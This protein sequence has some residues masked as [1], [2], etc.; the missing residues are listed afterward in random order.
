MSIQVSM[1]VANNSKLVQR[2]YVQ[3]S[4]HPDFPHK[5]R[6]LG[7]VWLLNSKEWVFSPKDEAKV[8]ALCVDLF[9]TDGAD[10]ESCTVQ[11][12][13]GGDF[14]DGDINEIWMFGRPVVRRWQRDLRVVLGEDVVIID[15]DFPARGGSVAHPKLLPFRT[16]DVVT[17]EVRDVPKLLADRTIAAHPRSVTMVLD[18]VTVS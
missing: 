15:G 12:R 14:L 4:F 9:G 6:N 1:K 2:L 5:A 13:V 17:L 16:T 18:A 10:V 8:R 11:V 7:G 3:T